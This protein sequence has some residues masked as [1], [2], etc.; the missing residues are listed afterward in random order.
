MFLGLPDNEPRM[1]TFDICK[2]INLRI[3]SSLPTTKN[4]GEKGSI[5]I[6]NTFKF[7]D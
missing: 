6:S 4:L 7:M 3:P 1:Q 2:L 5:P